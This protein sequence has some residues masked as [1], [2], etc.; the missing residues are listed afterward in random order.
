MFYSNI[1]FKGLDIRAV[2]VTA[3]IGI[4][5]F[6]STIGGLVLLFF[7]GRRTLML[8]GNLAMS[9]TLLFL[10]L[11]AYTHNT[12]GMVSMVLLFITFFE[13]SSGPIVWLYMS[14]IMRDK[15]VAVGT[16]L[17]W[18]LSLTISLSVPYLLKASSPGTLFLIFAILTSVGTVFIFIYM[19]ETRGIN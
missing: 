6:L 9:I 19:K 16:F 8:S 10:T 11:F 1:I 14:E 13:L 7:L 5:N 3:L 2:L 12:V 15:A 18:F 4:I 17:N